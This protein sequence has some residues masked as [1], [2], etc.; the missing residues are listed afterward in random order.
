MQELIMSEYVIRAVRTIVLSL[1]ACRRH[2]WQ[3]LTDYKKHESQGLLR[4][5]APRNDT[6]SD[7]DCIAQADT[8][9]R[10]YSKLAMNLLQ[11]HLNP[12]ILESLNPF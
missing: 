10:P 3:S 9:V 11:T 7:R 6:N 12:R 1:R 5:F 8:W 2:A 4:R